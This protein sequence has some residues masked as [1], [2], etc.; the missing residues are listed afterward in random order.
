MGAPDL[1]P[2]LDRQLALA[3]KF[4]EMDMG[5]RAASARA[6]QGEAPLPMRALIEGVSDVAAD[7]ELEPGGPP[8]QIQDSYTGFVFRIRLEIGIRNRK[9]TGS[10]QRKR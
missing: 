5:A 4:R 6:V 10:P 8:S 2:D 9:A 7:L 3:R 1:P